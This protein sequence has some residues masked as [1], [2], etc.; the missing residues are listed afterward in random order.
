MKWYESV[1]LAVNVAG[2]ILV[3]ALAGHFLCV[4]QPPGPVAADGREL[5]CLDEVRIF[6]GFYGGTH[7]IA[8][9][10][11]ES[12]AVQVFTLEYGPVY[13]SPRNLIHYDF[14]EDEVDDASCPV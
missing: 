2:A 6:Q 9:S 3:V 10:E 14:L 11:E 1:A 8:T 5:H 12:G 7:G 13:V 4:P